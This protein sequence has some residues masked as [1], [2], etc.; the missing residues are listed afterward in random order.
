M[1][2]GIV[3]ATALVRRSEAQVLHV[4]K[5][6][7]VKKGDSIAVNGVC[8]T[9]TGVDA[10]SFQVDLSEET[11]RRTTLGKIEPGSQ[12]NLERA[13]PADGRFGGHLV[14]GHVDGI[15]YLLERDRLEGS[16]ELLVEPPPGVA[17]YIVEKGSVA[18]DGVSLTVASVERGRFVVSVVPHTVES[19]NFS[20]KRPGDPVNLEVDI[21]A[22]YVERL[23]GKLIGEPDTSKSEQ[24]TDPAELLPIGPSQP[25]V[26]PSQV[27][28]PS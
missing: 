3:E 25:L 5:A 12:V 15:A 17:R 19:T 18:L 22:K 24:G 1:F 9:V 13:M 10:E 16:L 4:S 6:L 11:S 27:T 14:Q 28:E 2:T 7:D 23:A 26:D 21:V 20:A 8:V